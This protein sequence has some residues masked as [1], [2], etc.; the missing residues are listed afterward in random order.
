MQLNP[1]QQR[2]V[3]T[4]GHCLVVACPG[5]GKTRVIT[6]KLGALL[7]R[8]EKARICA[9]TFTR[10]AAGEL[11]HR[12]TQEIGEPLFKSA[13]RIG[14]FHSLAIRQLRNHN[15][16]SKVATPY[17]QVTFLRRAIALGEPG[18]E[19]EE[20]TA[21]IEKAKGAL[22]KAPEQ[23][24]PVYLA[25][26]KLL[27]SHNVCDLYDVIRDSVKMMKTGEIR[28]YPVKFMLVDEFQDTDN[29]QLEWV[30][31]HA[32][33]GSNITVVGDDD[34][35]IYGWRGALGY[36]GMQS[37]MDATGAERI[38]LGVNYRCYSEVLSSADRLI[39]HNTARID[40]ALV[41]GRGPGGSVKAVRAAGR[42]DEA[43]M[44]AE[45]IQA[46]ALPLKSNN[47]LFRFTVP[48]GSW[49]VLARNRR[50]LDPIEEELQARGIQY[51]RPPKESFWSRAPQSLLLSLLSALDGGNTGGIDHALNHGLMM[52]VG[53]S[54]ATEAIK[55]LHEQLHG[56]F[57]SLLEGTPLSTEKMMADEGAFILDF[58]SRIKAWRSQILEGR[59]NF[60]IRA[61]ASWFAGLEDG[62]GQKERIVSAGNTL[63]KLNGTI[64]MRVN[65]IT[66]VSDSK[67][68]PQGVQLQTMHGSKGL[69]FDKVW[70][71][72][73]E[74]TTCPSPKS[75]DHEEERRL[76]Y[77]AMTRAK[78][79]LL[80][81]SVMAEE[82]SPFVLESGHFPNASPP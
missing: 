39:Q 8:H 51:Y 6:T 77:V 38:T 44:V 26:A 1:D 34:Q 22:G 36:G 3:D 43:Q 75:P 12:V 63:C 60:A 73:T 19:Y 10:D 28:A 58:C 64:S 5:S 59:F 82:P 42:D 41:A 29:I 37:F 62:E 57:D 47:P 18:M 68:R 72:G 46:D 55:A 32:R 56:R 53:R 40:K 67:E 81:S 74:S 11:S 78:N 27:A 48:T 69:E 23:D 76:M 7:R 31:E 24:H 21:I 2:V 17:E 54:K 80:M 35:S 45:A 50:L 15:K 65:A 25:Y 52:K 70:I 79:H 14:T 30:L 61:V 71:V 16:L 66:S 4:D 49:A 9:V 13:C 33:A 20:A